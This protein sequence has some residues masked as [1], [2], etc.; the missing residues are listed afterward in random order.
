MAIWHY[1]LH[2]SPVDMAAVVIGLVAGVVWAAEHAATFRQCTLWADKLNDNIDELERAHEELRA[3][4]DDLPE[5]V[6]VLGNDG[7]IREANAHTLVLT[8]RTRAE[9]LGH[10]VRHALPGGRTSSR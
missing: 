10:Y 5:A 2:T 8:G 7:R 3:L 1:V 9:L 4:L 6:V